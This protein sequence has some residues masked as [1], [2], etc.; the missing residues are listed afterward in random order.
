MSVAADIS[1]HVIRLANSAIAR[2]VALAIP[3]AVAVSG[4]AQGD[5]GA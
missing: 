2:I 1:K 3:R 4:Y 5:A